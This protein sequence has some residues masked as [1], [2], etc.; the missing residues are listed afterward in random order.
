MKRILWIVALLTFAAAG[1]LVSQPEGRMLVGELPGGR[2]L[3][4]NGW[5]VHPAGQ[6]VAMDTFPMASAFTVDKKFLLVLHGGYNPPSL[7]SY[8]PATMREV[9]KLALK[10]AW[11]GL[12]VHPGGKLLYV[13]G[14]AQAAVYEIG[15]D[16]DG[17]LSLLRTFVVTPEADRKHTDFVGDVQVSP[18][19]RLVYLAGLYTDSVKVINPQSGRVIEDFKSVPRPYRLL[20]HPDGRSFFVS[21]WSGG[22]VAQQDSQSGTVLSRTATGAHPTDMLWRDKV[23]AEEEGEASQFAARI[24]VTAGN[25][26]TVSVLGVT[27]A[28]E[29]RGIET[30]NVAMEAEQPAGMTPSALA[31]SEDGRHLYVV[32]SDANAVAVADV[33]GPR[34]R[35][36]GFIPTGWYPIAARALA[37]DRL[38]IFN[39]RG[40]RSFPN[41]Q[42]PQPM[43]NP[44]LLHIGNVASQYV[45][46]LQ[47]GS[48]SVV[49]LQGL[50]GLAAWTRTVRSN[51]PYSQMQYHVAHR[52]DTSV[53][54]AN[55]SGRPSPIEHVVYIIKENRTYDQVLGDLG[56]GNSDP[57]MTLFGQ[58]ISPNHHKLANEFVLLD[59][60][61]VNADVS[62]DG[63]NWT[64]A[65]IAPDYV[66]KMWP[67]S[68]GGRRK[69]YDYEGGEKAAL[70]PA[71]Y[72][73]NNVL[74][75]GLSLRNYGYFVTNRPIKDVTDGVHVGAV[76]DPALEP[77]THKGFRGFDLEYTDIDR[78]KVFLA[79]L[80]RMESEKKF[81]RFT[82]LRIGNDHTSGAAAGKLS[83]I[84]QMAD[85]DYA[86]GLIV[87]GLTRSQFWPKMAIFVLEDDAQN[88]PDHVDSHRSPAYVISPYVRRNQ[89]DSTFY[90]T[91]SM[92]RTMELILGLRPMT[93]FD[94]AS[95]PMTGAFTAVADLKAYTAEKPRVALDTRNPAMAAGTAAQRDLAART[96]R[97]DFDEA[98]EIDD[99]ELNDILWRAIRG[100]E[101]PPP[102]RSFFGR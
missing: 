10:D 37:G 22:V 102:V 88:G 2:Y 91:T 92:L 49:D 30:I 93:T 36:L 55:P 42:G 100:S 101:P 66:Q 8:D 12:A 52:G 67:N 11:L 44:A 78:A 3:L 9:N 21:S 16:D 98:D 14:G 34:S 63:H 56:R 43:R 60:F 5:V 4:P 70:P 58:N 72:I 38:A 69:H 64:T 18:D 82:I 7:V 61:Y 50:A 71:G 94:A 25:T 75:K 31:L 39:G 74:A 19:G 83:P 27:A 89:I 6:Q 29:V 62:A 46:R 41:P 57:S 80:A 51:S 68:Y 84:A 53:I 28:K 23:T 20:F 97:M 54:P 59:N 45:G 33:S 90:N 81:P 40:S 76:R 73:W 35:V 95:R 47:R 79:D 99:D 86:F 48:A 85:N 26:N 17:R 65:A 15:V 87:E 13:S 77:H 1:L 24:F 96:A 32:C